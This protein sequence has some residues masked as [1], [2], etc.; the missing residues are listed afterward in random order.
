MTMIDSKGTQP[1]KLTIG[2]AKISIE[3]NYIKI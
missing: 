1:W 3:L 2:L